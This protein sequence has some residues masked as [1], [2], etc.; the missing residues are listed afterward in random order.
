MNNLSMTLAA[1][2]LLTPLAPL[3]AAEPFDVQVSI[4]PA[5]TI[6]PLRPI[7]R[8]FGADE[9]NYVYMKDGEKLTGELGALRPGSVFFRPHNLLT[10]GD[11]TPALK[12]GSSNAY[13]YD[14]DGRP[15]Y[16][17]EVVDRIFDTLI[18]G[19]VKPYVEVG[20]MPEVLSR[21]P[22]PYRHEWRP[23][24]PYSDIMT[25]WRQPPKD[26]AEW[27]NLV[28]EMAKHCA[29]RYGAQEAA[30]WYWETWNE[31]NMHP[32]GYWG[33]TREEFLRLH[34]HTIAGVRRALP[35]ARVGGPHSAGDGGE[36]TRAF[37]EHCLRGKNAATGGEG[38]PLD[39]IAFHAKGAPRWEDDHIRMGIAQQLATVDRGFKIVASFPELR[40]T[41]IIIG[42]C[43][44]E[45]CAACQGRQFSY[46]NGTVYSSYTA[47]SFARLHQLADKRGVRLEGALT[48]AFEF[49]DQPYFAGFRQLASN[50]V[51]LP[52]LNVFRL[53]SRMGGERVASES[54]H[55]TPLDEIIE[56]GVRD[57]PDVGCL[58]SVQGERLWVLVW[59]YH[60]DDLP[61]A[62]ASVTVSL[63]SDSVQRVANAWRVDEDHANSYAAWQA[64]G[65]P[66]A[67]NSE[68]YRRLQAAS[69]LEAL[70]GTE[71]RNTEGKRAELS[72][73]VPRQGVAL[74]EFELAKSDG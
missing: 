39:F 33:G 4:D 19:G 7:W 47:A 43:D 55:Q 5:E 13:T 20:F 26:F 62:D 53:F 67:P 57:R 70:P 63:P 42:E 45:G 18:A 15:V 49:E 68:Q 30:S 35:E 56:K 10:S 71:L 59:H 8:F 36:F 24:L 27:E 65:S 41:P 25:G 9:P 17:W 2:L 22:T 32:G 58:A 54:S 21:Q 31:A 44:P 3:S 12:W 14:N 38:T 16:D 34:D 73:I 72:T 37:L 11:K 23:G 60:D 28:Y 52:V 29:E 6:G 51:A 48:W 66:G 64:M 40:E 74:F 1:A 50:G 69:R 46:R 61:G